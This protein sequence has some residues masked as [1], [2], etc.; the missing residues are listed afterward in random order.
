VAA[1]GGVYHRVDA[2]HGAWPR[3]GR[4]CGGVPLK[5]AH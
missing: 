4:A 1:R 2:R 5:G 3:K